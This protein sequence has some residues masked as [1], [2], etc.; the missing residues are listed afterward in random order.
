MIYNYTYLLLRIISL[1][2]L[3]CI[4]LFV[5]SVKCIAQCPPGLVNLSTQAEVDN[6]IIQYPNCTE[7]TGDLNIDGAAGVTNLNGLRNLETVT[8]DLNI[9]RTSDLTD[10]SG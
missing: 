9:V 3:I 1:R 2:L 8:R 10:I 5:F 4:S 7:I 6:F